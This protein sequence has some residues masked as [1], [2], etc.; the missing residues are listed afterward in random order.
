MPCRI[1]IGV[2]AGIL[3]AA[4]PAPVGADEVARDSV[5]GTATNALGTISVHAHNTGS[6]TAATGTFEATGDVLGIGPLAGS[7]GTFHF[8]G[9]VTCLDVRGNRAGLIYPITEA[10]GPLAQR[11]KG[12]AVY[13][14]IIDK[15]PDTPTRIGFAGP[16]PLGDLTVC[17]PGLTTM[18]AT[19]GRIVVTDVP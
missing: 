6:G 5:V 12:Q 18:S 15:G 11:A 16:A 7:L 8:V 1:R 10:D 17:P 14:T 19:S 4:W 13:V 2:L 9:P 3:L